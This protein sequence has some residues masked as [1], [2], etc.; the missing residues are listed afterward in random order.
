MTRKGCVGSWAGRKVERRAGK[1][2]SERQMEGGGG[3]VH[4]AGSQDALLGCVKEVTED[5]EGQPIVDLG[6][7]DPKTDS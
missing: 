5:E 4:D 6:G 3:T 2:P 7:P 1:N